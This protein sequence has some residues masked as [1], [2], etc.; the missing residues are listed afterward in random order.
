MGKSQ[1]WGLP[2]GLNQIHLLTKKGCA[3][4]FNKKQLQS[5][6]QLARHKKTLA[7]FLLSEKTD[8]FKDKSKTSKMKY[9]YLKNRCFINFKN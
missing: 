3:T 8:E 7:Y 4:W 5:V 6:K 1:R 9:K 2:S